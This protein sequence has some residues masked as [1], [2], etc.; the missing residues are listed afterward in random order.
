MDNVVYHA[1]PKQR[2][3]II[4]PL[5]VNKKGRKVVCASED[6]VIASLFLGRTGGDY[7]CSLGRDKIFNVPY[8][9]ERFPGAFGLR[10]NISASLYELPSITFFKDDFTWDDEVTSYEP[11]KPIRE[12]KVENAGEHLLQLEQQDK[13]HIYLYPHRI[14]AIPD[15]DSDLVKKSLDWA[16]TRGIDKILE[17]VRRFHPALVNRVELGWSALQQ[18]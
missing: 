3:D 8:L 13:L 1:S 16:K 9:V 10:Y 17:Q 14:P 11:V 4:N 5:S 15:D 18:K 6:E 2:L 12:I 7:T